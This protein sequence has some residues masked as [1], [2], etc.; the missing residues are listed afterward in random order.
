MERKAAL[1]GRQGTGRAKVPRDRLTLTP[2][3]ARQ[4]AAAVAGGST[5]AGAGAGKGGSD[6]KRARAAAGASEAAQAPAGGPARGKVGKV[7]KRTGIAIKAQPKDA[8]G[9][10]QV[11][12]FFSSPAAATPALRRSPRVTRQPQEDDDSL[13]ERDSIAST[14]DR[15]VGRDSARIE[16]PVATDLRAAA[17]SSRTAARPAAA[18][19]GAMVL[20]AVHTSKFA[21]RLV[22]DLD[23][24]DIYRV[25]KPEMSASL[26]TQTLGSPASS[27]SGSAAPSPSAGRAATAAATVPQDDAQEDAY[28]PGAADDY[29]EDA[30]DHGGLD[31]VNSPSLSQSQPSLRDSPSSR[32]TMQS[33]PGAAE[34]DE[35]EEEQQ[36]QQSPRRRGQEEEEE[37]L[38]AGGEDQDEDQVDEDDDDLSEGGIDL[39]PRLKGIVRGA[40]PAAQD[41]IHGLDLM[42]AE[43]SSESDSEDS[44]SGQ[45]SGSEEEDEDDEL[46]EQ[47]GNQGTARAANRN[48][49][50]I[51][52]LPARSSPPRTNP[53][54]LR[55]RFARLNAHLGERLLYAR[56]REGEIVFDEVVA[57]GKPAQFLTP[58]VASRAPRAPVQSR[59]GGARRRKR[60]R[61]G[62]D[63]DGDDDQGLPPVILPS[64]VVWDSPADLVTFVDRVTGA[65]REVAVVSLSKGINLADLPAE[66]TERFQDANGRR[67]AA[68]TSKA[69]ALLNDDKFLSGVVVLP[70]FC[71]KP[72]E[73]VENFLQVFSVV[74]A[75]P[76]SLAI[77]VGGKNF[78]LSKG[79]QFWVPPF[80][81]YSLRNYSSVKEG[82]LTFVLI[83]PSE[84]QEADR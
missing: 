5:G 60:A 73:N 47:D 71:A 28:D 77:T 51:K 55:R 61:L 80:A 56:Q 10:E 25:I 84:T 24:V 32:A 12:G 34:R 3:Q 74:D 53:R 23:D 19:A 8:A 2:A 26:P 41:A 78:L 21:P 44:W 48:P 72:M 37:E 14:D 16:P 83:K 40:A 46:D 82:R 11:G 13:S 6:P 9:L 64:D 42:E 7:G 57:A 59:S 29:D 52:V 79:D 70:P 65:A 58:P 75:Q 35:D 18:A 1:A 50:N 36:Q 30:A 62:G 69:G 45:G 81:D 43:S 15:P 63:D 27:S 49:Y 39:P 68:S 66:T 4:Q 20:A 22:P 31:V 76:E 38:L 67:H 33:G 54:P 17:P